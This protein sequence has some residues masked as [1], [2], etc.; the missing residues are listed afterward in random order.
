MGRIYVVFSGDGIFL[1]FWKL[2]WKKHFGK[3]CALLPYSLDLNT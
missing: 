3:K 1:E 2:A